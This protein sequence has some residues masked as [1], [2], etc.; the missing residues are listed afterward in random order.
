[1][2]YLSAVKKMIRY[3][4]SFSTCQCYSYVTCPSFVSQQ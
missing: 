3:Q 4:R 1:V 2:T